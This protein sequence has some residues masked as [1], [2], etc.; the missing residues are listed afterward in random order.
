MMLYL[1]LFAEICVLRKGPQEVPASPALLRFAT[2]FYVFAGVLGFSVQGTFGM[3]LLQTLADVAMVAG[4]TW[5]LLRWRRLPAR[6]PQTFTALTGSGAIIGF[7]AWPVIIWL[8]SQAEAGG[9][10]VANLVY[11]GLFGWSLAVMTHIL[12]EA[13]DI[14]RGAA[15]GLVLVYIVASVVLMNWLLSAF[16]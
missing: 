5:L 15:I 7:I 12:R 9:S 13:L 14:A 3:S 11:L 16:G 8:S 4:L 6:F 10:G 1:R 2:I